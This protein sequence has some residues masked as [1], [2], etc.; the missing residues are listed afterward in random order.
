M[1]IPGHR[2]VK[3]KTSLG[4]VSTTT[5]FQAEHQFAQILEPINYRAESPSAVSDSSQFVRRT[6]FP[7][8]KRK[9]KESTMA[10]HVDRVEHHVMPLFEDRELASFRISLTRRRP[11]AVRTVSWL[12]C[13]GT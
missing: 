5:K 4:P 1:S 6:Y 7:F 13:G 3:R 9:W 8:Y 12:T 10:C 11:K 2:G